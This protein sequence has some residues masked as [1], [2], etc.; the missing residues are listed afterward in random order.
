MPG[1]DANSIIYTLIETGSGATTTDSPG[2]VDFSIPV[3]SGSNYT[4]QVQADGC[5]DQVTNISVNP[6]TNLDLVVAPLFDICTDNAVIVATSTNA[7]LLDW[8]GQ[9]I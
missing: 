6:R 2:A 9:W 8:T 3:A 1:C 5:T 7:L 4:L